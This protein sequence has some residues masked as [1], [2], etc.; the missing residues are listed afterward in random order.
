MQNHL[1]GAARM[2][3]FCQFHRPQAAQAPSN[4]FAP[5]IH[6]L[7]DSFNHLLPHRSL[8]H[9]FTCLTIAQPLT[10]STALHTSPGVRL[11]GKA[12]R[13]R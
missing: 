2:T 7:T 4:S 9:L 11:P 3:A 1:P 6:S 10:H 12:W 5:I 8:I 13:E